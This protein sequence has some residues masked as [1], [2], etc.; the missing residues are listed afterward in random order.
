MA[1]YATRTMGSM[2]R[3]LAFLNQQGRRYRSMILNALPPWPPLLQPVCLQPTRHSSC[4]K[5]IAQQQKQ[6]FPL[7]QGLGFR[8]RNDP[9]PA[10]VPP[11][12]ARPDAPPARAAGPVPSP[13]CCA[14]LGCS[15]GGLAGRWGGWAAGQRR[16]DW[17]HSGRSIGQRRGATP[18]T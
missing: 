6:T 10:A 17:A 2:V 4:Q 8:V 14:Q 16:V 7:L 13:V 1:R 12:R 9:G 11:W 18:L 15:G 3:S 5:P